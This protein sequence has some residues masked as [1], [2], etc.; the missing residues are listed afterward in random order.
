MNL[1]G[2]AGPTL[3]QSRPERLAPGS[4]MDDTGSADPEP[5]TA[6]DEPPPP[7]GQLFHGPWQRLVRP[8]RVAPGTVVIVLRPGAE[9]QLRSPGDLLMPAWPLTPPRRIMVVST[10]IVR[11]PV[12]LDHLTTL[13]H[14]DLVRVELDV[15]VRVVESEMVSRVRDHDADAGLQLTHDIQSA[16]EASVRA[17]VG[18]NRARDVRRQSLAQ[19]LED[20]WLPASFGQHAVT[21]VGFTVRTVSWS[22]TDPEDATPIPPEVESS[23]GAPRPGDPT[24]A[25]STRT[26]TTR[27]ERTR[28]DRTGVDATDIDATAPILS[29]EAPEAPAGPDGTSSAAGL[30][31][32]GLGAGSRRR[33]VTAPVALQLVYV[34]ALITVVVAWVFFV[35]HWLPELRGLPG[36][37][38]LLEQLAPLA[39][40]ELSSQGQPVVSSQADHSGVPAAYLLVVSL[41]FAP[42]ARARQWLAR[43]ALGPLAYFGAIGAVVTIVGIVVR[44]RLAE[45]LLGVVLLAVWVYAA[46]VTVWRSLWVEVD[47]LPRRPDKVA[48]M[49]AAFALLGPAPVALGRAIFAPD[50]RTAALSLSGN[51]LSLRMAALLTPTTATVYASGLLVAVVYWALYVCWPP[52]RASSLVRPVVV[53]V[54]ALLTLALVGAEA[55]RAAAVRAEV[56]RTQSPRDEVGFTC[57]DWVQRP[58]GAPARTLIVTGLSCRRVTAYSGFREVGG[59]E[60]QDSLSPV[61]ATTVGG[62]RIPGDLVGAEYG[63]VVVLAASGRVDNRATEVVGVRITDAAQLWRFTC[64][65]GDTLVV[66]FAG[67]T[68][69]DDTAAGRV[70][71][72][73]ERPSVAVSCGDGALRLDPGTGRQI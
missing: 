42:L 6:S 2:R 35:M 60:A 45:N 24:S 41:L 65:R 53:L 28:T 31:L 37:I 58:N 21:R 66:R 33:A 54:L 11:I 27:T 73:R 7:P 68:T 8:A 48:W 16:V 56:I 34:P 40:K 18:L 17:A 30:A 52:R 50:L 69:G 46:G 61:L 32:A 29:P 4:S 10:G 47:Q 62:A 55:G 1:R 20:R 67:A 26:E 70:T 3:Q 9:P 13:D 36:M 49:I 71:A 15:D 22:S 23:A 57:G 63:D 38:P 25:E 64:P 51:D 44:G 12:Q 39:S 19:L 14:E 5:G 72:A 59:S 43:L